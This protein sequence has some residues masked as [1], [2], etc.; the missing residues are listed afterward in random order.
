METHESTPES[1]E[2]IPTEEEVIYVMKRFCANNAISFV[3]SEYREGKLRSLTIRFDYTVDSNQYFEPNSALQLEYSHPIGGVPKID[4]IAFDPKVGLRYE[5]Y[6]DS[7]YI[8]SGYTLSKFVGE[9]WVDEGILD[10]RPK[11]D[12]ELVSSLLPKD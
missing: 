10:L 3:E 8:V 4:V 9:Q 6:S 1:V 2:K 11:D 5:N 12:A 7:R